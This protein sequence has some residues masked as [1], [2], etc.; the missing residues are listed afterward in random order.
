MVEVA[1]DD[2][3][4][5]N[6]RSSGWR[7]DVNIRGQATWTLSNAD[8][9]DVKDGSRLYYRATTRSSGGGNIRSS[10][11]P[12]AGMYSVDPPYAVINESGICECACNAQGATGSPQVAWVMLTP[13]LLAF[14]WRWQLRKKRNTN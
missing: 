4:S 12:A 13:L 3:F 2:A 6:L 10:L 7:S 8:W 14:I 9:S 11:A 1:N 5:V